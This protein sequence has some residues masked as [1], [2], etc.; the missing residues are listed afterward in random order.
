MAPEIGAIYQSTKN[1]HKYEVV[2]IGKHSE[3][4]EDMVIYRALYKGDFPAGQLWCRPLS[5]WESPRD[6]HPRFVKV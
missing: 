4:L 5:N 2:A 6:N 1:G 3:T